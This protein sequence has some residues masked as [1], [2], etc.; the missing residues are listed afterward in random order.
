LA[1]D[2]TGRL[3]AGP[4]WGKPMS[5]AE[6]DACWQDLANVDATRAWLAMQRLASVPSQAIAVFGRHLAPVRAADEKRVARLIADLD[7]NE[8]AAREAATAE[9]VKLGEPAIAACQQALEA[10]PTLE[11][12]R[13][14][15]SILQKI[16]NDAA[17]DISPDHLRLLRA[18]ET[19]E[20]IGKPE[21]VKLLE[22]LAG[23][24]AGARLTQEAKAALS[25][26]AR[27][28]F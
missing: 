2:L 24:A 17:H 8:F 14:L 27:S 18:V 11:V 10:R 21:A 1:W 20:Q 15:E 26:L 16:R 5:A 13:H 23:G 6:V 28:P 7:R 25:R 3:A 22:L 4:A 12:R 19:L 9:L